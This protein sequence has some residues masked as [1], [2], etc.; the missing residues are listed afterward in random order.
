MVDR[1]KPEAV[2]VL[3]EQGADGMAQ[4][5]DGRSLLQLARDKRFET[6][7]GLLEQRGASS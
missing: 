5:P 2:R 6:I 3:L 7:A 4:F 1:G